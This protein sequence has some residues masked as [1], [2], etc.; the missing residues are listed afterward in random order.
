MTDRT[1]PKTLR[2]LLFVVGVG[3]LIA[4][5]IYLGKAMA[6]GGT[7]WRLLRA[8]MYLLLGLFFTLRYGESNR[9]STQQGPEAQEHE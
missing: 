4:S 3:T 1:I 2:W 7:G 5:G 9:G 8:L 6:E